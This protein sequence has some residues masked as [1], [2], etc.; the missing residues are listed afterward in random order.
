VTEDEPS[1]Y[2]PKFGYLVSSRDLEKGDEEAPF[3]L[4]RSMRD[5]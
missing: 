3:N 5:S 4:H 2:N 1:M